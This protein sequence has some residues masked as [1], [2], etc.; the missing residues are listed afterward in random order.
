MIEKID[1][2][3]CTGCG[4]CVETCPIDTLRMEAE[5]GKA[6]I[7]YPEDCMTCYVCEMNCPSD[8]ISVH[9]F[10]EVLPLAMR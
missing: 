6:Y 1:E 4:I 10:K 5:T 9:P 8:A 7:A 2:T 3:R